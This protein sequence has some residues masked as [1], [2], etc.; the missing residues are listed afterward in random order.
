MHRSKLKID[1]ILHEIFRKTW[2]C[3]HSLQH[4]A[5]TLPKSLIA[6]SKFSK[7][8]LC[9]STAG[10]G[11]PGQRGCCSG[12]AARSRRRNRRATETGTTRSGRPALDLLSTRYRAIAS[13][14]RPLSSSVVHSSAKRSWSF[15]SRFRTRARGGGGVEAD[16]IDG[17]NTT[18]D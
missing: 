15:R 16:R 10:L 12:R 5:K 4:F 11:E 13:L 7:F 14:P 17:T 1:N 6:Y 18:E 9:V 2:L 8:W 3:L